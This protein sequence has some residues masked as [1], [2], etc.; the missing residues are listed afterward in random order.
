[1]TQ[2]KADWRF[3]IMSW[4]W[5]KICLLLWKL[6][7]ELFLTFLGSCFS[8][9]LQKWFIKE[10][11]W[12]VRSC[13]DSRGKSDKSSMLLLKKD[14]DGSGL[15][16]YVG[17]Q[18]NIFIFLLFRWC[19]EG[20]KKRRDGY[21]KERKEEIRCLGIEKI[22]KER[23]KGRREKIFPTYQ[24][25]MAYRRSLRCVSFIIF[26]FISLSRGSYDS[27]LLVDEIS[28]AGTHLN[29]FLLKNFV[30]E[31]QYSRHHFVG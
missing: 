9:S 11:S 18:S 24:T 7:N 14:D 17:F 29:H 23:R 30:W 10:E 16:N 1:M 22:W 13:D 12:R 5:H 8:L 3:Y 15:I 20:E 27:F 25:S 28:L 21:Y 2:V 26:D 4:N 19:F 31:F 6:K